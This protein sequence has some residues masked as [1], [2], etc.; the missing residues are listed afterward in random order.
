MKSTKK[1]YNPILAILLSAI[2][3]AEPLCGTTIVYATEQNAEQ[4]A[5]ED[6]NEDAGLDSGEETQ[7]N[8]GED[9]ASTER[10]D[11]QEGD[12]DQKESGD[13]A[14]DEETPEEQEAESGKEELEQET[15][16]ETS[17]SENT[18]EESSVSENDLAEESREEADAGLFSGMPSNYILSSEQKAMKSVLSA[19]MEQFDD[20]QE[21]KAYVERQVF[22]FADTREEAEDIANAYRAELIEY[23]EG[24]AV[25]KLTQGTS[26]G[27]ALRKASDLDNNLPAVYPDYYRYAFEEEVPQENISLTVVEEEYE[28]EDDSTDTLPDGESTLQTYAEYVQAYGEPNMSY[29]SAYY[30]WHHAN[31]GSVYAWY[32]DKENEGRY[33]K[34]AVLDTGVMPSDKDS[35]HCDLQTN[36]SE[37][38]DWLDKHGHGTHVAGII[39]AKKDEKG[40]AGIAPQAEIVNVKVLNNQGE[41]KDSDIIQGINYVIEK[42]NVDIINMSL[43]GIGYNP[44]LAKVIDQAYESGIAIFAGAGNDGGSNMTYPAALENVICVA[45]IDK[46][47]QRA[48]VSNH[49]SWVDLSAPGVDIWSMGIADDPEAVD[50]FRSMSGTSQAA[51]VAAGEAAVILSAKLDSIP[52]V[53]NAEKVKALKKVMQE[54]AVSVGSGMGKGVTKLTKIFNLSAAAERPKAPTIECID[55]SNDTKQALA[56]RIRAQ[57]GTHLYYTTNGRNPVYKNGEA[58]AGT[59]VRTS[60]ETITVSGETAA[61]GTVKAMAVSASGAVS[62]I[63]SVTWTLKPY[64]KNI[65]IAGP[66][67]VEKNKTIQLTAA[68]VPTYASNKKITWT[69]LTEDGRPVD[70]AQ[71][72]IDPKSG[73]IST[74]DKAAAG[75]YKVTATAQDNPDPNTV[76]KAEYTV[77]VIESNKAIQQITFKDKPQN[78]M[79]KVLW[80]ESQTQPNTVSLFDYVIA[81][82]KDLSGKKGASLKE[83]TDREALKGRLQ[84]TSSKPAVAVVDSAGKVT[85]KAVGT[86]TITVKAN[87]N[88][89]KKA[90]ITITVKNAVTKITITT[91]KG[92]TEDKNFTVARGKSITLKANVFPEKPNDK[93]VYWS[94]APG[95]ENA[96][97]AEDM[98]NVTINK[99]SGKVTVKAEAKPGQYIVTAVASDGQG[100]SATKMISVSGGAIGAI[101]LSKAD[102]KV[103]LYTKKV[104]ATNETAEKPNETEITV[105]I[106]GTA[107]ECDPKAYMITNSNNSVVKVGGI[108]YSPGEAEGVAATLQIPIKAGGEQYGKANIVIAATDGSNKKA[109]CTVTVKGGITKAELVDTQGGSKKV[110]SL[111]LFRKGTTGQSTA[112]LYAKITGPKEANAQAYTVTSSNPNIVTIKTV[113]KATG[114]ISIET[115]INAVGKATIT[116]MATDG[117]KKKATCVVT[118]VNPVSRIHIAPK[119]G[120]MNFAAKGK[121]LQLQATLECEHGAVSNKKVTWG[122]KEDTGNTVT[123]NGSGKISV[124]KNTTA[125]SVTVTAKACDG[126]NVQANY[127]VYITEPVKGIGLWENGKKMNTG[128]CWTKKLIKQTDDRDVNGKGGL[129]G[130]YLIDLDWNNNMEVTS[131]KNVSVSSS[132]PSVISASVRRVNGKLKVALSADRLGT[133]TITIKAMDGGGSQAKY[134][135][136]VIE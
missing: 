129:G 11:L 48:T 3:L 16:E 13:T 63:T 123:I 99:T 128:T 23:D 5:I 134:K 109:T 74:T 19:S 59:E 122:I 36:K 9:G 10:N 68:V 100:A 70:A 34:V 28:P 86:T 71:I 41:G 29:D 105:T 108:T 93:R 55:K 20:S 61:R 4:L 45:A 30:Q 24:V 102:Q 90:A 104:D 106:K 65:V 98:K 38:A 83:I 60:W 27:A 52:K 51:A 125:G 21:G 91:D 69:L 73:K 17:V 88:L 133:A 119:G 26:V 76:A 81:Q 97:T 72:K 92:R 77:E 12:S 131:L 46:N 67:R 82:E 47:N 22:A 103:T 95:A 14:P 80:L 42:G 126:S 15:E 49:G 130:C 120:N 127:T 40:G 43:G 58:G 101:E 117:S 124:K 33:I 54:N 85:A 107:G 56:I 57:N 113:D 62:S 8:F 112:V 136:R 64:V 84:W 2:L 1:I 115:A 118:V 31:V 66:A 50:G 121:S 96:A 135:F 116:L 35:L 37:E 32:T 53:R 114:K 75:K 7:D 79:Q 25:L 132:N 110:S 111:K 6:A 78:P 89:A 18:L 44:A 39:G 87:D 94:I